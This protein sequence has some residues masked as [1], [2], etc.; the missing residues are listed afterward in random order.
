MKYG[1]GPPR[2]KRTLGLPSHHLF[3]ALIGSLIGPIA[4]SFGS[5]LL[6][7]HYLLFNEYD[8][9]CGTAGVGEELLQE[10]GIYCF[11]IGALLI[12]LRITELTSD[13]LLGLI[14]GMSAV[15]FSLVYLGHWKTVTFEELL[16]WQSF[17]M[18][19]GSF[20]VLLIC[21]VLNIVQNCKHIEDLKGLFFKAITT[22]DTET[23]KE[24]M[25][26]GRLK[27][28]DLNN[29]Y[30]GEA[31]LHHA[32]NYGQT[33]IVKL[34]C[35]SGAACTVGDKKG[36]MPVWKAIQSG[37]LEM[38]K[39]LYSRGAKIDLNKSGISA[40][41]LASWQGNAKIVNFLLE[42]G[43]ADQIN[44]PDEEGFTPLYV[45]V[46]HN[47]TLVVQRLVEAGAC[48]N[49][50][51]YEGRTPVWAAASRGLCTILEYLILN[52]GAASLTIGDNSGLTPYVAAM[53]KS[54]TETMQYLT[55]EQVRREANWLRRKNYIMFIT[56]IGKLIVA[57]EG[58]M[59]DGRPNFA[60]VLYT[61]KDM[62]YEIA[63]FL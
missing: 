48:I 44:R 46:M 1:Q 54:R 35:E 12:L 6:V 21:F 58:A 5:I 33:D 17:H 43:V 16:Q 20:P 50:R 63:S 4:I 41:C 55:S 36:L 60:T 25:K 10:A 11:T 52:G 30:R 9:S 32:C 47:N 23:A 61:N 57:S 39:M 45:A 7:L 28:E 42:Q 26:L 40:L 59:G 29:N 37:N 34:L 56:G 14:V 19:M 62:Q 18:L 38:T 2:S 3:R 49:T 13:D 15:I 27:S 8:R 53:H 24:I 22:G 31:L 51:S